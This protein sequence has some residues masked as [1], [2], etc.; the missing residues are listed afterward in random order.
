MK[1]SLLTAII[2]C[3]ILALTG[4]GSDN[5]DA[6][7]IFV[8]QIVSDPAFDGDIE[9]TALDVFIVTQG[10]IPTVQSVFAGI[11]PVTLTESRAFLDFHLGGAQ[12][13]P[14][15]A[16]IESAFLDIFISSIQPL[17]GTIPIRIELVSF[18]PPNL[19]PTDFNRTDQPPL[20]FT[21]IEPP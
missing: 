12:G 13:V 10:M 14:S 7:P 9:Q 18:Q 17:N 21:T 11:N 8:T 1:R 3:L 2:V 16:I 15:D 20:V 6:S 4:C 5:H 19:I